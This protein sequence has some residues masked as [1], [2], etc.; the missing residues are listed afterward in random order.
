M[1]IAFNVSTG[2]LQSNSVTTLPA[3]TIDMGVP[4]AAITLRETSDDEIDAHMRERMSPKNY[5]YA[6]VG[7]FAEGHYTEF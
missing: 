1:S 7:A 2:D 4:K 3:K 5:S 6:R